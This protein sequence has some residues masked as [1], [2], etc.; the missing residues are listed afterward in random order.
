MH[1]TCL[2]DARTHG[3]LTTATSFD[4]RR[5]PPPTRAPDSK[6]RRHHYPATGLGSPHDN[7]HTSRGATLRTQRDCLLAF[8]S[9]R[10]AHRTRASNPGQQR[11]RRLRIA[12]LLSLQPHRARDALF[13]RR[14]CQPGLANQGSTST[15]ATASSCRRL[16]L[17][18]R[19]CQGC[20][21]TQGWGFTPRPS[22]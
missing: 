19:M 15:T 1:N 13:R 2:V 14:E 20:D 7:L 16:A 10:T 8:N 9:D 11:S 18:S 21:M 22:K 3:P 5:L 12:T 4:D 17:G 6:C